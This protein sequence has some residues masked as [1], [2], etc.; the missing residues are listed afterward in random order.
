MNGASTGG[1]MMIGIN[2]AVAFVIQMYLFYVTECTNSII[3][4]SRGK[5]KAKMILLI[6]TLCIISVLLWYN[7]YEG[8]ALFLYVLAI[9]SLFAVGPRLIKF[10]GV[11]RGKQKQRN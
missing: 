7:V 10:G 8:N 4:K 3:V 1:D 6:P 11:T 5:E 9:L 2:I